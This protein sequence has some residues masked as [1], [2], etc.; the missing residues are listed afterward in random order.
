MLKTRRRNV[1]L[2]HFDV[3]DDVV[4]YLRFYKHGHKQI[5]AVILKTNIEVTSPTRS[6]SLR[7]F[8]VVRQLRT[9]IYLRMN[10]R[11]FV[12]EKVS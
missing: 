2:N 1:T 12:R 4:F 10:L 6:L 5:S 3:N 11:F 8:W 7:K 9:C